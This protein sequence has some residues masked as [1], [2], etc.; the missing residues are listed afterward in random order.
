MTA[1]LI[2]P[3][4][5]PDWPMGIALRPFAKA[6]VGEIHALM[7]LC[8]ANGFGEGGALDDWW[9]RVATDSEFDP[10]L[11]VVA[12]DGERIVGFALVW[13]SAFIKDIVVRPDWQGR[14]LGTAMLAEIARRLHARGFP[15][16]ALKV[17]T[18]NAEARRVYE[19][20]GFRPDTV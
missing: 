8:Y 2:G 5:P 12:V 4:P 14:G 1:L 3:L 10:S 17:R 19:R 20:A 9:Q 6:D 13:N 18:A 15:S 16:M 7:A 11:L